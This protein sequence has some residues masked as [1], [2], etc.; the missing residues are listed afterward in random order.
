MNNY[1][2]ELV[3]RQNHSITEAQIHLYFNAKRYYKNDIKECIEV[4]KKKKQ[5]DL[6][7]NS[8]EELDINSSNIQEE[9][10]KQLENKIIERLFVYQKKLILVDSE[11]NVLRLKYKEDLFD[12]LIFEFTKLYNW[13]DFR[14]A[15][16][17]FNDSEGN[18]HV[19]DKTEVKTIIH[20]FEKL[21]KIKKDNE[22][23]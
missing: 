18:E 22:L 2:R 3:C 21:N 15:Y 6:T 16:L 8:L 4:M 11:K 1:F 20:F 17:K 23:Y 7:G 14:A 5:I 9:Y 10:D 19:I 13:L 12:D